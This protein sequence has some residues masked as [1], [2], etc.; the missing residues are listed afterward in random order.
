MAGAGLE[1]DIN[2]HGNSSWLTRG[3]DAKG[4]GGGAYFA[5][6]LQWEDLGRPQG[7]A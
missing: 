7:H 2:L 5:Q 1:V 3:I 6:R 4:P